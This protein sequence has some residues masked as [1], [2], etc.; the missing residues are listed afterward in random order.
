M[1]TQPIQ[2]RSPSLKPSSPRSRRGHNGDTIFPGERGGQ[3]RPDTSRRRGGPNVGC[4]GSVMGE[5]KDGGMGRLLRGGR[6]GCGP[7]IAAGDGCTEGRRERTRRLSG[8]GGNGAFIRD[9]KPLG[10]GSRRAG[11]DPGGPDVRTD[12]DRRRPL[13]RDGLCIEPGLGRVGHLPARDRGA[14]G[15]GG[16]ACRADAIVD[17]GGE[18]AGRSLRRRRADEE[19]VVSSPWSWATTCT[20]AWPTP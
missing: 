5:C 16:V 4:S 11:D 18:R 6:R 7:G 12:G 3:S 15:T 14:G 8:D 2:E 17:A 9:R 1:R 13:H 20:W 10:P 19:G